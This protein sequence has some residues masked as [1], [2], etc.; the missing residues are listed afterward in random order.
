MGHTLRTVTM[1]SPD[2]LTHRDDSE[3]VNRGDED[4]ALPLLPPSHGLGVQ[5]DALL[6]RVRAMGPFSR[7]ASVRVP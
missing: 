2:G 1:A 3:G 6:M 5:K 4:T 7:I